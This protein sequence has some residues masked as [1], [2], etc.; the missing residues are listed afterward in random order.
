MIEGRRFAAVSKQ[1][2]QLFPA[3]AQ[4]TEYRAGL[5]GRLVRVAAH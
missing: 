2:G 5:E 3:Q 1:S 4:V